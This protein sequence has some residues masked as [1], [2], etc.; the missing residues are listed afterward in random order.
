MRVPLRPSLTMGTITRR[1][2]KKGTDKRRAEGAVVVQ[3]IVLLL[4]SC[5]PVPSVHGLK[6]TTGRLTPL[7]Q[8]PL[9]QPLASLIKQTDSCRLCLSSQPVV[10][11]FMHFLSP[12]DT[13]A[14]VHKS[15]A[16]RIQTS[17]RKHSLLPAKNGS[18]VSASSASLLLLRQ[19]LMIA[20]T[21]ASHVRLIHESRSNGRAQSPCLV[22]LLSSMS[23][24]RFSLL[25]SS[26][27]RYL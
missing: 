19:Q 16:N 12:C 13:K 17:G 27:L 21:T 3:A 2:G 18:A 25:F 8:A 15:D 20:M 10:Y 26:S 14:S 4:S 7:I 22:L 5:V 23:S 11:L 6:P 1:R 9:L 24:I